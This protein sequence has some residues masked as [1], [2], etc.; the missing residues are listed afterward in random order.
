VSNKELKELKEL[1]TIE[2]EE[3]S[4]EVSNKELSNE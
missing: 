3:R 4:K 1:K 2:E